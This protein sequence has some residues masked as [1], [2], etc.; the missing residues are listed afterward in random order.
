MV[1]R[2]RNITVEARLSCFLRLRWFMVYRTRNITF[3]VRIS[4]FLRSCWFMVYRTRNITV[5]AR[6][7]CFLR[8]CWFMVYR[9]RNITFEVRLSW[10]LHLCWF[11]VYSTRNVSFCACVGLW[12]IEPQAAQ[13]HYA[14]VGAS[15]VIWSEYIRIISDYLMPNKCKNLKDVKYS[16]LSICTSNL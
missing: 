3:G 14:W 13:A 9:K 10:V 5:G 6:F 1:Y 15:E 12:F 8:L 2:T 4:C 16:C 7:S 11:M